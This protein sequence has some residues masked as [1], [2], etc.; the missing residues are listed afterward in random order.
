VFF[1][2]GHDD[3]TLERLQK[4]LLPLMVKIKGN[5]ERVPSWLRVNRQ[6]VPDFL[7][8]DPRQAFSTD[9]LHLGRVADPDPK[10]IRIQSGMVSGSGFVFGIRI[11][12]QE[13]KNDPQ[14]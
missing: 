11:R 9:L 6:F 14:K 4:E 10:W 3:A 12:I 8:K 13:G 2:S 7:V 5:Y 1:I